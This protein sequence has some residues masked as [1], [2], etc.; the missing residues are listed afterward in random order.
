MIGRATHERAARRFAD[1]IVSTEERLLSAIGVEHE[2][3]VMDADGEIDFRSVIHELG[4]GPSN[5]DPLDPFAYPL[6]SGA[7]ITCDDREAEVVTAPEPTRPGF[8]ARLDTSARAAREEVRRRLPEGWALEGCSTHI[9]VGGGGADPLALAW[10]Y[11]QTFAPALMLLMDGPDAPGLLVR[12]RPGRLE[13]GGS[14]VSGPWLRA[15]CVF[16][17]ASA[18]TLAD[19]DASAVP[20]LAVS[21]EPNF[22]RFGWYVDRRA[23]GPD[24]YRDGRRTKLPLAAGGKIEAQ[25]LLELLW[26]AARPAVAN[27]AAREEL[28]LVD[29][30]VAGRL[31]LRVEGDPIHGTADANPLDLGFGA[32]LEPRHRPG[33]GAAPVMVTWDVVVLVLLSRWRRRRAYA[34]LPRGSISAFVR[35]LDAGELDAAIA[36]Y[37]R[38]RPTGRRLERAD[39]GLFDAIGPRAD[40][41]PEERA[42]LWD[43]QGK[44]PRIHLSAAPVRR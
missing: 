28:E 44:A 22:M 4:F 29:G 6:S 20:E 11:L 17:V 39:L 38:T 25:R 37:L 34:C 3:R 12:P 5:L 42:P 30:L 27:D 36:T 35:M 40:L 23:F 7:K 33:F 19:E 9:N 14:F 10:R 15:A 32:I 31:P 1:A 26:S 43:G 13:L 8:P 18:R 41:L 16:A 2:F 21:I 24:L